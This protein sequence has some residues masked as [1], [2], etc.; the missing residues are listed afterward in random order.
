MSREQK[1][2]YGMLVRDRIPEMIV[3]DG[4]TPKLR[5]LA[6]RELLPALI[7]KLHEE[8]EEVASAEPEARLGELADVREVLAALTLA[9]GFTEA[10][11]DEAAADKRAAR[12]GFARRLW[13]DEVHIP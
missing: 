2:V 3:A 1:L 5:A 4:Q 9:L 10:E 12:G 13:L 6:D 8:A 11:V 7:A